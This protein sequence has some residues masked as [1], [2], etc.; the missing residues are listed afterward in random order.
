MAKFGPRYPPAPKPKYTWLEKDDNVYCHKSPDGCQILSELWE[1]ASLSRFHDKTLAAATKEINAILRRVQKS[2]PKPDV[3]PSFIIFQ[4][5]PFLV[6]A[7]YGG[8]GPYD[9]EDV[10][11]KALG[12]KIKTK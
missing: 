4:N 8:V 9:D 3:T 7:S 1:A 11:A 2:K 12:L 6:W 5:R 10:I